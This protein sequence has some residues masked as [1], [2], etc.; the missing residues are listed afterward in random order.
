M[1]AFTDLPNALDK[2][3]SRHLT[4]IGGVLAEYTRRRE[5]Y[6]ENVAAARGGFTKNG[7]VEQVT[8]DFKQFMQA[9]RERG[10]VA[11]DA[12]EKDVAAAVDEAYELDPAAMVALAPV[13]AIGLGDD[14]IRRLASKYASDRGALLVLASGDGDAAGQ[15]KV[16]LN[17]VDEG[18]RTYQTKLSQVVSDALLQQREYTQTELET[19]LDRMRKRRVEEP[20]NDL[21]A[22]IAGASSSWE[23][24]TLA[25]FETMRRGK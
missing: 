14:D 10:F 7:T 9:A 24:Q 20:L 1:S 6:D 16:A 21:A 25:A 23:L 5:T 8:G 17:A 15:I 22:V 3:V 13:T 4:A 12:M 11:L 19:V 2:A 18:I